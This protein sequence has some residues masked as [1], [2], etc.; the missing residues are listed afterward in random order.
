VILK[1]RFR[2]AVS[3]E[4]LAALV[5]IA[6]AGIPLGDDVIIEL[7]PTSGVDGEAAGLFRTPPYGWD[8]K[9][10]PEARYLIRAAFR[11][12]R[13]LLDGS[14]WPCTASERPMGR[15]TSHLDYLAAYHPL[16]PVRLEDLEE[17]L[18]YL[19]GHEIFHLDQYRRDA[20]ADWT[21]YVLPD[22]S[23]D[24]ERIEREAE[25]N[26]H[27]RLAVFRRARR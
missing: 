23:H 19:F 11:S 5:S 14:H 13:E 12:E 18:V 17:E 26:G 1:N 21:L 8:Q 27:D 6:A 4:R 20:A 10:Y 3:D 22:G 9:R 2:R 7:A 16:P 24:G 15:G 25:A